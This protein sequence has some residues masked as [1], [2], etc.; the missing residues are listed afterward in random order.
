VDST[1]IA[2]R[3]GLEG[4]ERHVTEYM[5]AARDHTRAHMLTEVDRLWETPVPAL[6]RVK[7]LSASG[8]ELPVT[9]SSAAVKLRALVLPRIQMVE[10][11]I[12]EALSYLSK[13]SA[14]V[15]NSGGADEN[16]GVNFIWSG[17]DAMTR[18]VTVELRNS[19][20]G[21]ALRAVCDMAGAR[22]RV[23]GNVVIVSTG[24]ADVM[25]TRQFKVPPGFLSTGASVLPS[26][27][28]PSD[29]FAA[30]AETTKPRLGRM[31]AKTYFEQ[32]DIPFPEGARAAYSPAQNLLT[33][34]NT[35]ENLDRIAMI[36][37]GMATQMQK[38]VQVQVILLKCSETTLKELGAD[39][40]LGAFSTGGSDRVFASGGT[41]GNSSWSSSTPAGTPGAAAGTLLT[42]FQQTAGPLTAGTRSSFDL[43]ANGIDD[44]IQ[45]TNAGTLGVTQPRSP[46][47]LSVGGAFTNPRF[48]AMLRGLNQKKSV[49]LSVANSIVLKSGQ[50]ATSFSG[51]KFF[52]PTEFDPPQIPQTVN[53]PAQALIFDP[54]NGQIDLL[55]GQQGTAP[56]T[57][58]TPN[59]FQERDIGAALEVEA[60]V[61]EDGYTVNLNLS[62][63]FSEFDG[64]INYG[65]PIVDP[66]NPNVLLTDN[67]IIQ[68]IFSRYAEATTVDIYDGSTIAIGGLKE[69]REETIEDKVPVFSSIPVVGRLF[70]SDVRRST[71]SAM[72]Y[73]VSVK[74]VDP[75][76]GSVNA[77]GRAAEAAASGV[78]LDAPLEPLLPQ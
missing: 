32:Q 36:V 78:T 12:S 13:Q 42:P 73:F 62:V 9:G 63:L 68:P 20:L 45:S 31:D 4:I 1:N 43:S 15:D 48:Q 72:V 2:A 46:A 38:Q 50:K 18:P 30:T 41:Y 5:K 54:A 24:A 69:G 59:S 76:G 27:S 61:G 71:R 52:Y 49:D 74:V 39:I 57:P 44:L 47:F 37:D 35:V 64:F 75:S 21:D 29:P 22:Y 67:R 55:Q 53:G 11:P 65:A 19:R 51:R 23:D 26:E 17:N 34:T 66:Q 8:D 60:T 10:T 40:M 70:K 6:S 3:R 77:A 25:E 14:L 33:I 28:T 58:A 7:P 56:V 16:R